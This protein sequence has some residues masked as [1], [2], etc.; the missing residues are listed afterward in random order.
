MNDR[1]RKEVSQ[2]RKGKEERR[3]QLGLL[4]LST[5]ARSSSSCF[6]PCNATTRKLQPQA[7]VQEEVENEG[8]L[9]VVTR[10]Y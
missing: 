4:L 6:I 7:P 3:D 9:D 2:R 5:P 10:L 1:K 8:R